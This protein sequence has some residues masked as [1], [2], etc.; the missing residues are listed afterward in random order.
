MT[1]KKIYQPFF[2]L[3]SAAFFKNFIK[4]IFIY[5]KHKNWFVNKLKLLLLS[6]KKILAFF[7][8][9]SSPLSLCTFSSSLFP[10]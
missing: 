5:K 1:D 6:L 3:K 8:N 10:I 9:Y 4:L 2:L 7:G